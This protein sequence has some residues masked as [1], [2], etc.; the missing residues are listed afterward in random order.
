MF[1]TDTGRAPG[2]PFDCDPGFVC[3]HQDRDSD[4]NAYNFREPYTSQSNFATLPCDTC[5]NSSKH[6]ES[7]G[8][9]NDQMSSWRNNSGRR[10][11]WYFDAGH[12]GEN[13]PMDHFGPTAAVN[14]TDHESDEASSLQPC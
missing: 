7:N 14:L 13:H 12:R 5:Q 3:L 4:G 6:P 9:F 11:C 2:S 10:Y 8:T 1:T